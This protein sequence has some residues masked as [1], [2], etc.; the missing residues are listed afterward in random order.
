MAVR[1]ER[2]AIPKAETAEEEYRRGLAG[3]RSRRI[4]VLVVRGVIMRVAGGCVA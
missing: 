3:G 4:G 2:I 1:S